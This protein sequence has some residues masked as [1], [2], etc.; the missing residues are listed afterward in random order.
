[1]NLGVKIFEG[2]KYVGI[3]VLVFVIIGENGYEYFLFKLS[4]IKE[5]WVKF[6]VLIEVVVKVYIEIFKLIG[7]D[8]KF[9]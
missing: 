4:L 5:E 7:V 6:E 3:Y 1:M 8:V 9:E 2:Y